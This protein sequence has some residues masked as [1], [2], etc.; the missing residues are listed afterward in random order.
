MW[1]ASSNS[2]GVTVDD[3]GDD[4]AV[5]FNTPLFIN[6]LNALVLPS[7]QRHGDTSVR[8]SSFKSLVTVFRCS[9]V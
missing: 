4:L 7:S 1:K 2:G 6:L 8:Y 9:T 5:C 3:D